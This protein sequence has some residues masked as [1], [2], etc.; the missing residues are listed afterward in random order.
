MLAKRERCSCDVHRP[1]TSNFQLPTSKDNEQY[2]G[3]K[4]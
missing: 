2:L 1:Q 4:R 3:I